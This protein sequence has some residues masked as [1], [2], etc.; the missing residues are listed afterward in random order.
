MRSHAIQNAE[1]T[2]NPVTSYVTLEQA[3]GHESGG[4]ENQK[5]CTLPPVTRIGKMTRIAAGAALLATM[6]TI[7]VDRGKPKSPR[8]PP[9]S[10]GGNDPLDAGDDAGT[11]S[12]ESVAGPP[13]SSETE[14]CTP[15]ITADGRPVQEGTCVLVFA[16]GEDTVYMA[17]LEKARIMIDNMNYEV[18]IDYGAVRGI[19]GQKHPHFLVR[20][21]KHLLKADMELQ[22]TI[23]VDETENGKTATVRSEE[24]ETILQTTWTDDITLKEGDYRTFSLEASDASEPA[25][26]VRWSGEEP[27]KDADVWLS[28]LGALAALGVARRRTRVR[29]A[30]RWPLTIKLKPRIKTGIKPRRE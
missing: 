17:R 15:D 29:K 4:A 20:G 16:L 14:R 6:A 28:M 7:A 1:T 11:G 27:K 25:C 9:V 12:D 22:G 10:A 8:P 24:G 13:D 2:P 3:I 19:A 18:E 5:P 30:T 21:S 23:W 26:A